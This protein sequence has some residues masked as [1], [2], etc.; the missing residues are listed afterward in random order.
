MRWLRLPFTAQYINSGEQ[1]VTNKFVSQTLQQGS[2]TRRPDVAREGVLCSLP[3]V[4]G[5]LKWLTFTLFRLF[6]GAYKCSANE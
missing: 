1:F 3:Y 5:I 4:L 6:A 2:Q